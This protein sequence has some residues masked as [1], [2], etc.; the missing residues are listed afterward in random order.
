MR[1]G[2]CQCGGLRYEIAGEPLALYVC[3]CRECRKQSASA[4][5]M[6]LAVPRAGFCVTQGAPRWWT[7]DTDSGRRLRC[8]FCPTCGSRVWHEPE[9]ASETITV[10][11]GS[12]DEPVDVGAAIHIWTSRK[13]RGIEIPAGA[14]QFSQE[15]E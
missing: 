9:G 10:K 12:L 14:P 15:P 2:G 1:A 5:G 4:F 8:A 13:L 11:A 3:H 6:S 7:R